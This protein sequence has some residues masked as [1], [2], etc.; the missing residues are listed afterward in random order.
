VFDQA[1]TLRNAVASVLRSAWAFASDDLFYDRRGQ[2]PSDELPKGWVRILNI[3]R[4]FNGG[5]SVEETYT[6]S[7]GAL[8]EFI[9]GSD[10]T[11]LAL[12]KASLAAEALLAHDWSAIGYLP[13]VVEVAFPDDDLE[14]PYY[15]VALTFRIRVNVFQ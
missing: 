10:I 15:A 6:I 11:P 4:E 9:E 13:E 14:K 3:P 1:L 5:R 2:I 12:Q 7:C 8:F